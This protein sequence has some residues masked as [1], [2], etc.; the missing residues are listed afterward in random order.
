MD[1]NLSRETVM[2]ICV[3]SSHI[4]PPLFPTVPNSLLVIPVVLRKLTLLLTVN[5]HIPLLIHS[6]PGM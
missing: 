3:L 4:Y 6:G 2:D 5:H 1:H